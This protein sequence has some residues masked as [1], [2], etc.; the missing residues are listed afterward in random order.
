MKNNRHNFKKTEI[1]KWVMH[2]LS[3]PP[4]ML[5]YLCDR[6]DNKIIIENFLPYIAASILIIKSQFMLLS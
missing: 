5:L 1:F 4:H 3:I 2:F 6:F